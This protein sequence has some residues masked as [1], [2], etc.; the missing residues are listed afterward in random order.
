MR[1]G[2]WSRQ[3]RAYWNCAGNFSRSKAMILVVLR[4][5]VLYARAAT[6]DQS[7]LKDHCRRARA[8]GSRS[9]NKY[10]ER[11]STIPTRFKD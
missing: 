10:S 4:L 2:C 6:D 5:V 3:R 11:T 7:G 9:A 1:K 8:L